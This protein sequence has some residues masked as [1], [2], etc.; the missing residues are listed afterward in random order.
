MTNLERV[1][2]ETKG[3]QLELS[4]LEVY[5]QENGLNPSEEYNSDNKQNTIKIYQTALSILESIANNPSLMKDYKQDDISV[6]N[7]ADALQNRIDQLDS[8]IRRMKIE[9]ENESKSNVFMLFNS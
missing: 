8:K 1:L 3:M 2:I 5:L 7:F 6:S 4:E 9:H